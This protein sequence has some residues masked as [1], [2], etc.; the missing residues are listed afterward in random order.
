[1]AGVDRGT[2]LTS[3]RQTFTLEQWDNPLRTKL[4]AARLQRSE[5]MMLTPKTNLR[6]LMTL[7]AIGV[8]A[9]IGLR[10][11]CSSLDPCANTVISRV[12]SPNG[13]RSLL[14]FVRGC[15]ATTSASTQVSLL[16]EDDEL[17]NAPGNLLIIET[18][19][20]PYRKPVRVEWNGDSAAKITDPSKSEIFKQVAELDG[21]SLTYVVE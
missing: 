12:A 5:S 20:G 2:C 11:T 14:V 10:W 13:E 9:L 18:L 8:L 15:G 3:Q 21:V 4:Q 19:G 6:W 16:D 17:P 7:A 1:V